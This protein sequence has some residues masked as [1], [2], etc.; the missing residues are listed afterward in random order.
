M[1]GEQS[2]VEGHVSFTF[3]GCEVVVDDQWDVDVVP[4]SNVAAD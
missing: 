2:L 1:P 4:P 3:D